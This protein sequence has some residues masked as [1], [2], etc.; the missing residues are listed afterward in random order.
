MHTGIY[1]LVIK[2]TK[3]VSVRQLGSVKR[4]LILIFKARRQKE[5]LQ[6]KCFMSYA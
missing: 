5:A 3:E 1:S 2:K 4:E 6:M